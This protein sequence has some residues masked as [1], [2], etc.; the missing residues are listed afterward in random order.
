MK[1][2][3]INTSKNSVFLGTDECE[4]ISV[5]I[6]P[7][8]AS[9]KR[10]RA[11]SEDP[12][13]AR[14]DSTATEG[15]RIVGVSPGET[16]VILA[17]KDGGG[18]EKD[19]HVTVSGGI[20]SMRLT[21]LYGNP[22]ET[23]TINEKY[24]TEF[25]VAQMYPD[26]SGADVMW[27]SS[28]PMVAYV[29]PAIGGSGNTAVITGYGSGTAMITAEAGNAKATCT[30]NVGCGED[31]YEI[32]Y[33]DNSGTWYY[34]YP[35]DFTVRCSSP[36][37]AFYGVQIDGVYLG[38]SDYSVYSDS[39]GYGIVLT[40]PKAYMRTLSAGRHLLT[41]SF[42]NGAKPV[43]TYIFV[44]SSKDPPK[45]GDSGTGT[46]LLLMMI[47]AGFLATGYQFGRKKK[48]KEGNNGLPIR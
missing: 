17:A 37:Y 40:L 6:S 32:T 43:S 33:K 5:S 47:S 29:L 20:S 8:G 45:T 23:V 42:N 26:M 16:K 35:S 2:E 38:R 13:I 4:N 19:I 15:I 24:G 9:N 41:L 46:E 1:V 39:S 11:Y 14:L 10:I 3:K 7:S 27:S 18:A 34:D 12:E 48:V 22:A 44:Q 21:D 28:N 25:I 31:Y 36:Q 30:V